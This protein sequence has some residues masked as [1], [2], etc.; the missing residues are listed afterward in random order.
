[1]ESVRIYVT[2]PY[3][4]A[5][6][7][8][9]PGAPGSLKTF[10]EELSKTHSVLEPFQTADSIDGQI[11][12][13]KSQIEH[14]T[15]RPIILIGHSWGAWLSYIFASRYPYLVKKIILIG[16]GSFESE[17]VKTMN[18]NRQNR[19]TNEENERVTTL[20]EIINNPNS[21]KRK[22]ALSEFGAL[23]AKADSYAPIS[24][25]SE[26]LDFCPDVFEK[27]MHE[28][29]VIRNSGK[30]LE[31]GYDIE[32][33]VTAI[34]GEEDSHHYEGVR[35]PLTKVIKTFKFVLLERCGH[36]PWN[37]KYA[38]DVFYEILNKEL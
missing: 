37:E 23:M 18:E 14:Y 33:P 34:H 20:F 5:V 7:H 1:M 35:V 3:E 13:L 24:L 32:C 15:K 11:N 21:E 10:A 30:L 25:E 2:E 38:R 16:A 36:T 8:G 12:E 27:C 4:I 9:G 17:Y 19:L 28:L 29:N 6:I 26:T 22:N 31:L